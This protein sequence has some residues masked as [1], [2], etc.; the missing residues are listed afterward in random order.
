MIYINDSNKDNYFEKITTL[1]QYTNT[2]FIHKIHLN[3]SFLFKAQW[4]QLTYTCVEAS[5][6]KLN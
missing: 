5:I 1:E 6:N 4:T 3:I 2:F